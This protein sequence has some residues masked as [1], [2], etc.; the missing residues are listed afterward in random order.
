[1]SEPSELR[2]AYRTL[3]E[4]T[5]LLGLSLGGWLAIGLAAGAGYGL[6]LISP[7]GWRVN[8]S[9]AIIGLG[10]PLALLVLREQTTISPGRLL[11]AII[12]WRARPAVIT[13]LDEGEQV[14]VVRRGG[15]RLDRPMPPV[16]EQLAVDENGCW[17]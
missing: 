16:S 9:V 11:L 1:M 7:L 13:G 6:L 15:V 17:S 14:D 5:R 8:V 2:A 4:P 10:A 3:N 12:A